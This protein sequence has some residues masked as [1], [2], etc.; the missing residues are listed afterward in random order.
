MEQ[1]VENKQIRKT[2]FDKWFSR[3]LFK[4]TLKSTW[5]LW[6]IM[7]L[8]SAA[9]FFIINMVIN[10]K[11]I[12]T[13]IDMEK[14]TVYV[15]DEDLSWLQILGLLEKYSVTPDQINLEITETSQNVN[16]DII[17]KN[18]NSLAQSGISFSLDDYGTGY[19]NILRI[20]KLPLHIIKLDKSF[21]DDLER[22]GMKTII[23]E[24]IAMLKKMNKKILI[25]G[26]ETYEDFDYFR[27]AGCDYVQGYYFSKPLNRDEFFR[28]L[29]STND[30]VEVL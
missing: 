13:N 8:G 11:D 19:S 25:E 6:L 14:V 27:S 29:E 17:E 16:F 1:V 23:K 21:V 26:V 3:P 24:T 28:F 22:P 9:I 2:I 12:F 7:T 30:I 4:Q 5:V 20:T 10:S 18:I 15:V